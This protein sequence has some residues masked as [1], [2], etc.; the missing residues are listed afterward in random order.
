MRK[1]LSARV[2]SWL[3][4]KYALHAGPVVCSGPEISEFA[5]RIR[6]DVVSID[7]FDTLVFRRCA[8]PAS[9]FQIQY[10]LIAKRLPEGI[11][12]EAWSELRQRMEHQLSQAAGDKE[13]QFDAIYD[14]I[15]SELS[16]SVDTIY[17]AK[18]TELEIERHL[19]R[20]YPSVVEALK[21]CLAAGRKIVI[22]TDI[23]L[24][25]SFI[26]ELLDSFLDF[27]YALICSSQTGLTKRHGAAFAD[28]VARYPDQKIVHFGDNPR[29]D[30][31]NAAGTGVVACLVRWNR[32]A[33]LRRNASFVSYA[34]ALGIMELATPYDDDRSERTEWDRAQEEVAWRWAFVLTDFLLKARGISMTSVIDEVWLL[35]RDCESM[36][37]ALTDLG[38][39][40]FPVPVK[41]V[42]TSR[43]ATYPILAIDDPDRFTA[44]S[45]RSV[46]E[47]DKAIGNDLIAA[48][49]DIVEPA[50]TSI[51][52]LDIGWKG[53]V[54][55]ALQKALAPIEIFGLYISLSS[56]AE[57]ATLARSK[58]LVDWD[59]KVLNQA[60]AE[61][62]AGY[63]KGSCVGYKRL[64]D[65]WTPVFKPSAG[66]TAPIAYSLYLR[67]WLRSFLEY[68]NLVETGVSPQV[69]RKA[70]SSLF[71]FPDK[72]TALAFRDW[73]IGA[74]VAGEPNGSLVA[75]GTA[76]AMARALGREI[77]GNYWPE[78]ALWSLFKR[79]GIVWLAQRAVHFRR[80][81]QSALKVRVR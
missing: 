39:D 63:R 60:G 44:W 49:R 6:A 27:P 74:A 76:D 55:V 51:L 7:L 46:A 16:L 19:I 56:E 54:Q 65:G 69:R 77:R 78:L 11:S 53:R 30:I 61:A 24:P 40:F 45:G 20:P 8:T 17:I 12:L 38:S 1:S 73:G 14:A 18:Q 57:P 15:G 29:A 10:G 2:R 33:F 3:N 13:I 70:L 31:A 62:L 21:V 79:K 22:T 34:C 32:E 37:D 75:G 28:L 4:T 9:V 26:S 68:S 52:I 36:F 47:V 23:Y 67:Y 50:S 35:S 42:Y 58:I 43:A 72:V 48:Y 41:Y 80:L 25:Y 71:A 5:E 64:G 66:D 59:R 81:L